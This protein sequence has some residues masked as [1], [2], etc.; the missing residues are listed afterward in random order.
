MSVDVFEPVLVDPELSDDE[1]GELPL[2]LDFISDSVVRTDERS[3]DKLSPLLDPLESDESD[4]SE[5]PDE[6]PEPEL[7]ELLEP[8]PDES[9]DEDGVL[10]LELPF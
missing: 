6:D 7:S 2:A 4:E 5:E 10:E 9:E 8:E 1:L 3:E